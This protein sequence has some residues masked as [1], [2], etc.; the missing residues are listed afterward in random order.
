MNNI[1]PDQRECLHNAVSTV[2]RDQHLARFRQHNFCLVVKYD[3][4]KCIFAQKLIIVK[5]YKIKA[6]LKKHI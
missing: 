5:K 1:I 6:Y 2:A 4:R 3:I